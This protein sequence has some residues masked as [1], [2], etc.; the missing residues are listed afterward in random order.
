MQATPKLLSDGLSRIK[1][2]KK[3]PREIFQRPIRVIRGGPH[4]PVVYIILGLENKGG[5]RVNAMVEEVEISPLFFWLWAAKFIVQRV[6]ANSF[7]I[8]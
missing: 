8:I 4:F 2:K 6:S 1:K 7:S 3:K 5:V